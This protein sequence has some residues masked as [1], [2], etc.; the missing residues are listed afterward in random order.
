MDI[1]QTVF[2]VYLILVT[3]NM[4]YPCMGPEVVLLT[5]S[6]ML[7]KMPW[8]SAWA[9]VLSSAVVKLYLIL[10]YIK[11]HDLVNYYKR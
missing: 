10:I 5:S 8:S 7:A 4:S 6:I 2:V 1:L 9:S 3:K 11:K